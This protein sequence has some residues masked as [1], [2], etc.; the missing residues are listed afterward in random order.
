[1]QIIKTSV[2]SVNH[3]PVIRTLTRQCLVSKYKNVG[4]EYRH[5]HKPFKKE[6]IDTPDFIKLIE[7]GTKLVLPAC[8]IYNYETARTTTDYFSDDAF[9]LDDIKIEE[10]EVTCKNCLKNMGLLEKIKYSDGYLYTLCCAFTGEYIRMNGKLTPH[11]ADAKFYK[12]LANAEAANSVTAFKGISGNQLSFRE[13]YKLTKEE[14]KEY[15]KI[16]IQDAKYKI[17]RIELK[18]VE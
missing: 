5:S 7:A 6:E 18:V 10:G 3:F 4:V 1:M 17:V 12:T 11:L 16:R 8:K 14:Q 9:I 15:L 13:Y 2:N